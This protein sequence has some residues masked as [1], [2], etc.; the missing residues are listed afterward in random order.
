MALLHHAASCLVDV[1]VVPCYIILPSGSVKNGCFAVYGILWAFWW[2]LVTALRNLGK[3]RKVA[4]DMVRDVRAD[5]AYM[6]ATF[7]C[8]DA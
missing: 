4:A 3:L 5:V 6:L 7:F 8:W 2:P 1:F